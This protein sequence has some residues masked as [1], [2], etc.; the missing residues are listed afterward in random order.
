MALTERIVFPNGVA[1]IAAARI[2]DGDE[3]LQELPSKE[4]RLQR[5]ISFVF[6]EQRIEAANQ[7]DGSRDCTRRPLLGQVIQIAVKRSSGMFLPIGR[8]VYD[9]F[10][11]SWPS[12]GR[13]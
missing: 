11:G 3:T 7:L 8:R 10:C 12:L 13:G 4:S 1:T 5:L 9:A 2:E 6:S